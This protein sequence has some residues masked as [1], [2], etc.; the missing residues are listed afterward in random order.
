MTFTSM[1]SYGLADLCQ[2]GSTGNPNVG[3]EW[4]TSSFIIPDRGTCGLCL[5]YY[6]KSELSHAK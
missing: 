3:S 6:L 1:K 5:Q 2:I 4:E